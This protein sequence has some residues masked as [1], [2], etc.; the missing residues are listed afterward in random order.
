MILRQLAR[1]V[2]PPVNFPRAFGLFLFKE[3]NA[4]LK[5]ADTLDWLGPLAA[6]LFFGYYWLLIAGQGKIILDTLVARWRGL[7][8]R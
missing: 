2:K 1:K 6:R 8:S 4:L 3:R 7:R 5:P